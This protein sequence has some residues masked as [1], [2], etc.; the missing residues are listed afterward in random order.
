MPQ[1]KSDIDELISALRGDLPTETDQERVRKQ[2]ISAGLFVGAA[3]AS[4][5]AEAAGLEAGGAGLGTHAPEATTL[6]GKLWGLTTTTKAVLVTVAL[7]GGALVAP[8]FLSGSEEPSSGA[9]VHES[10]SVEPPARAHAS[11]PVM[12]TEVELP[13]APESPR[14]A[15][16]PKTRAPSS[17][18]PSQRTLEAKK[19]EATGSSSSVIPASELAEETRLMESALSAVQRGDQKAAERFLTLHNQKYPLGALSPERERLRARISAQHD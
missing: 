10:L 14:A 3:S 4:L 15:E 2:L 5:G 18:K 13:K 11:E 8:G 9:Q 7:G 19:P 17:S 16:P 1:R 6:V 12:P